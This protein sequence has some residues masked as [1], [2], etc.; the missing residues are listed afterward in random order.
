MN[1]FE[2]KDFPNS[3]VVLLK[4]LVGEYEYV[5]TYEFSRLYAFIYFLV[6]S[7]F[8]PLITFNLILAVLK[9][10]HAHAASEINRVSKEI[11]FD[12]IKE[13][14]HTKTSKNFD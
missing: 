7:F 11:D 6:F 13:Y 1:F 14:F 5:E 8:G 2:F 12:Y 10:G 3:I 9:D 4:F